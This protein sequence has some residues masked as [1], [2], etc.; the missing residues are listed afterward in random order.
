[1]IAV[2]KRSHGCVTAGSIFL[3]QDAHTPFGGD[4]PGNVAGQEGLLVHR[5]AGS[6]HTGQVGRSFQPG[7]A[8]RQEL[9]AGGGGC[10][11][12]QPGIGRKGHDH[13]QCRTFQGQV[14]G[15]QRIA[16]LETHAIGSCQVIN[17]GL[18]LVRFVLRH[19]RR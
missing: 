15:G 14:G 2:P 19:V 13:F 16:H 12:G 4:H 7:D 11:C 3:R 18:V 17:Q 1:M 6:A 10:Q 5:E 9:H 8:N